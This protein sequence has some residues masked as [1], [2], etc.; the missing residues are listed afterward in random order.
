[1]AELTFVQGR[2]WAH[3]EHEALQIIHDRHG[4]G[5]VSLHEFRASKDLGIWYEYRIDITSPA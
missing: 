3:T 1:M 5:M 4:E 2:C